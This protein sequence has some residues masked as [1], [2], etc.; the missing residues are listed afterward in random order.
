[1]QFVSNADVS[2]HYTSL[3]RNCLS[4]SE[5]QTLFEAYDNNGDGHVLITDTLVVKI[6]KEA[7]KLELP[8]KEGGEVMGFLMQADADLDNRLTMNGMIS[9]TNFLVSIS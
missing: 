4:F 5:F 9:L 8:R 6:Q 2:S 1:M 3:I 7:E